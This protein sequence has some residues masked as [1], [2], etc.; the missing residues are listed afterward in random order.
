MKILRAIITRNKRRSISWLSA[1][2]IGLALLAGCADNNENKNTDI[3]TPSPTGSDRDCDGDGVVN[4]VDVDDD[5]DGLIEIS[6]LQDLDKIRMDLNG[7]GT[8]NDGASGTG[9]IGDM[10]AP[11]RYRHSRQHDKLWCGRTVRLR[12]GAFARLCGCRKLRQ[13][14][15]QPRMVSGGRRQR[16]GGQRRF[17]LRRKRLR[18]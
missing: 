9:H 5:N 6:S 4:D 14:R 15:H 16:H 17:K 18:L 7:D 1:L 10:G 12:I 2:A 3:C 13:Q 8:H 11:T